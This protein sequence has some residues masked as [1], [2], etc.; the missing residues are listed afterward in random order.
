MSMVI[1]FSIYSSRTKI[2][3]TPSQSLMNLFELLT[4]NSE[5]K[6]TTEAMITPSE[7]LLSLWGPM[8][9]PM[10][11]PMTLPNP[12]LLCNCDTIWSPNH[13]HLAPWQIGIITLI[14]P[15]MILGQRLQKGC[16]GPQNVW[17]CMSWTRICIKCSIVELGGCGRTSKDVERLQK[18]W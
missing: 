14:S 2:T 6:T 3:T 13:R 12:S 11:T 15:E 4:I 16:W 17:E 18:E 1:S 10:K 7:T 8:K 9:P 5:M